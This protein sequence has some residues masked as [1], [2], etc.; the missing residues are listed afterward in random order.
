MQTQPFAVPAVI[1]FVVA[2][3][4]VL[5]LIPR[6]RFY[7]VRTLKTLAD[8]GVWYPAN[9]VAGVA[10]VL[11]SA[12]YGAVAARWPYDRAA[13]DNLSTW[14]LHLAAFVTPLIVGLGVAVWYAKRV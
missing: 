5:G 13:S 12:V 4:L 11:A 6:N 8:D 1:L 9:R 10:V 14:T 2:I 7:G 3:P